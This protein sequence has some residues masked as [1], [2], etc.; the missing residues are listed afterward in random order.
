MNL[1]E[2]IREFLKKG[3]FIDEEVIKS[4]SEEELKIVLSKISKTSKPIKLSKE[5]ILELLS[6]PE[7]IEIV[8]LARKGEV[9]IIEVS[10]I[11]KERYDYFYNL[12]VNKTFLPIVSIN[13]IGK[14]K[15][16]GI[17]G[18]V[19]GIE[20]NKIYVEDITGKIAIEN[21]SNKKVWE[22]S[23]CLFVCKKEDNKILCN[24]IIYPE[25]TFSSFER[26]IAITFNKESSSKSLNAIIYDKEVKIEENRVYLNFEVQPCFQV[27]I[28]NSLIVFIDLNKVSFDLETI[29]K[30]RLIETKIEKTIKY[31]RDIFLLKESPSVFV[32][33]GK[34]TKIIEKEPFVVEISEN[35]ILDS[36]K[37]EIINI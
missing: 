24:E 8:N 30:T 3:Y 1:N 14:F 31:G 36:R 13:K 21:I 16:F 7:K 9:S 2:I 18:L 25:L 28:N 29:K 5:K 23:C 11:I 34:E 15:N 27:K 10:K 12:L 20:G 17:I 37:K 6:L 22:D 4:F 32:L 35:V 33:I 19:Y 26:E